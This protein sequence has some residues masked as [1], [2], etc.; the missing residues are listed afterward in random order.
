MCFHPF[1][2]ES[3]LAQIE[4]VAVALGALG[5]VAIAVVGARLWWRR[6]TR[7]MDYRLARRLL[8]SIYRLRDGV[9]GSRNG[10]LIF[11]FGTATWCMDSPNAEMTKELIASLKRVQE[12][13]LRDASRSH[14]LTLEAEAVWGSEFGSA[15]SALTNVLAQVTISFAKW[16]AQAGQLPANAK[17][18]ILEYQDV[19][20]SAGLGS[21]KDK[22]LLDLEA[23]VGTYERLLSTKIR[24]R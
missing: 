6:F 24:T 9:K 23:A 11:L 21:D 20:N 5:T 14:S 18:V 22:M 13:F 15:R 17:Q 10:A 19:V 8:T 1:P 2:Q 12:Q 3:L 4:H 7:Q 16:Q